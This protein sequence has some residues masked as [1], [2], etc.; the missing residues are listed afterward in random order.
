MRKW[1]KGVS[2]CDVLCRVG[3]C[4]EIETATSTHLRK[5]KLTLTHGQTGAKR[6]GVTPEMRLTEHAIL[7]RVLQVPGL[8][9]KRPRS[10]TTTFK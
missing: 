2:D 1:M 9:G 4:W 8:C 7:R 5:S 10:R 6:C 3:Y